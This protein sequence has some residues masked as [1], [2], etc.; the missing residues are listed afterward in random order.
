[1]ETATPEKM[2]I[3]RSV[4]DKL[5]LHSLKLTSDNSFRKILLFSTGREHWISW[6]PLWLWCF[7]LLRNIFPCYD[8][9]CFDESS[10]CPPLGNFL[11]DLTY[12]KAFSPSCTPQ[13]LSPLQRTNADFIAL[14][15]RPEAE[16]A[17][18]QSG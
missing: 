3:K 18:A 17:A 14:S 8:Q 12:K 16:R 9:A 2:M 15:K 1:M 10:Q 5:N 11:S 4:N 6:R 13:V 7:F